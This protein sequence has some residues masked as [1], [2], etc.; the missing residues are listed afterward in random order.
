[1]RSGFRRDSPPVVETHSSSRSSHHAWSVEGCFDSDGG[2]PAAV[3]CVRARHSYRNRQGPVG[4]RPARRDRRGVQPRPHRKGAH[5]GQRRRGGVPHYRSESRHV[6]AD[7]HAAR[8]QRRQAGGHR[9][10]RHRDA[11]D[12]GRHAGRRPGGD[13]HGHRRDAGGRRPVGPAS[14]CAQRGR[15]RDHPGNTRRRLPAECHARPRGRRH[16]TQRVADHDFLL[17]ARRPDQ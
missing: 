13:D 14:G 8:L 10:W 3:P 9:A 6:L 7:V 15:D 2:C 5:G 4:R 11:D 1:M 16:R 12:S 17:V